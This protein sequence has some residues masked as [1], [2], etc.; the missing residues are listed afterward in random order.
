MKVRRELL[1]GKAAVK[2]TILQ[3][4]LAWAQKKIRDLGRVVPHMR[5]DCAR[6]LMQRTL[7]TA[8]VPFRCLVEIDHGIAACLGGSAEKIF[9]E[10]GRHSAS[11]LAVV[12]HERGRL[13]RG[14]AAHHAG[15]RTDRRA[16]ALM[17]VRGRHAVRL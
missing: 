14:S 17:P 2:A 4:H 3:A 15:A 7:S 11:V 1:D 12:L 5:G 6:F 9:R 10:L 16:R 13:F 8:W